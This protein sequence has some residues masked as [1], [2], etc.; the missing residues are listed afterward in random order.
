MNNPFEERLKLL[1]SGDSSMWLPEKL[2]NV[3]YRDSHF[4]AYREIDT[5]AIPQELNYAM[6]T[7]KRLAESQYFDS[8]QVLHFIAGR[9][10]AMGS[11]GPT[12][13]LLR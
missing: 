12:K 13:N 11:V 6:F 4:K 10:G 2:V 1:T 3:K 5:S 9:C 8:I 7:N